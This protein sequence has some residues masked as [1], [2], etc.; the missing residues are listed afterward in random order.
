MYSKTLVAN[1][2]ILIIYQEQYIFSRTQSSCLIK[3]IV[4]VH[5]KQSLLWH[6][7]TAYTQHTD[8]THYL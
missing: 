7:S 1:Y 3:T 4:E 6:W 5:M 2:I 8:Y